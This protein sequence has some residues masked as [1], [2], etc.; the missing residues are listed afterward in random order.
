ME[1]SRCPWVR[2]DAGV[3]VQPES[4]PGEVRPSVV[5]GHVNGC[6]E[7][8]IFANLKDVVAG[9]QVF[10]DRADGQRAV[11][12]VSRVDTI[13]RTRSRRTR[14]TTTPPT[15][16]AAHHLRRGLRPERPV[17][18]LQCDRLRRLRRGAEDLTDGRGPGRARS[19]PGLRS[20]PGS[21]HSRSVAPTPSVRGHGAAGWPGARRHRSVRLLAGMDPVLHPHRYVFVSVPSSPTGSHRCA[22]MR[23]DEGLSAVVTAADA[24][25]HGLPGAFPCAGTTR[26]WPRRSRPSASWP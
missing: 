4:T 26:G 12:E 11:F 22:T 17:V 23:E 6:G 2:A 15:P 13:R 1:P 7:R 21:L 24:D 25:A 5:P 20:F 3:V 16:A 19:A 9:S 18:P 14:S 10:I 8:G